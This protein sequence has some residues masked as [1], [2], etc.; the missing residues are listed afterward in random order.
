MYYYQIHSQSNNVIQYLHTH[1]SMTLNY[2]LQ[3]WKVT[4]TP[5]TRVICEGLTFT[6]TKVIV[7]RVTFTCNCNHISAFIVRYLMNF[8]IISIFCNVLP[9]NVHLLNMALKYIFEY[10]YSAG[11]L[12]YSVI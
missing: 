4:L 12:P 5:D 10:L 2:Y 3:H 7:T 8:Y 11:L 9:S 6:L 1:Q